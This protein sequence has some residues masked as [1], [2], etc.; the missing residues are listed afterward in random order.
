MY[1]VPDQTPPQMTNTAV[2]CFVPIST[3]SFCMCHGNKVVVCSY[4]KATWQAKA[5][6]HRSIIHTW[7][8]QARASR[9]SS[10]GVGSALLPWQTCEHPAPPSSPLQCCRSW[11]VPSAAP[12][13]VVLKH[14][15]SCFITCQRS[16][17]RIHMRKQQTYSR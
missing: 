16:R 6:E 11:Q 1:A 8:N 7:V 2:L 3:M 17:V 4:M 9:A 14:V 10:V 15:T 12:P 13:A 5:W